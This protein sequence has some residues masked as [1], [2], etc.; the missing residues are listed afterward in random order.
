MQY[1]EAEAEVGR[2]T[3]DKTDRGPYISV[4]H[5]DQICGQPWQETVDT[6][7]N[8]S[9]HGELA[10]FGLDLG[11]FSRRTTSE[12]QYRWNFTLQKHSGADGEYTKLAWKWEGQGKST[13]VAFERP[14]YAAIV[15]GHNNSPFTIRTHITGKFESR[16]QGWRNLM[17][18]P[19]EGRVVPLVP[20]SSVPL[21]D[22]TT[23]VQELQQSIEDKNREQAPVGKFFQTSIVAATLTC[24]KNC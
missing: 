5:P 14:I 1:V 6:E 21:E 11:G 23:T 20:D 12:R 9:P 4:T 7:Y 2:Q 18:E 24:A 16:R 8:V 22:L 17:I 13:S 19:P 3:P 15:V 10:G